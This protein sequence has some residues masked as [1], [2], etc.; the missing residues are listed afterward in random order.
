MLISGQL[1][2]S[3]EISRQSDLIRAVIIKD[4]EFPVGFSRC[5]ERH[6]A[7]LQALAAL[8]GYITQSGIGYLVGGLVVIGVGAIHHFDTAFVKTVVEIV[9]HP[10]SEARLVVGDGRDTEGHAL[11]RCVTQGS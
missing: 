6:V 9:E 8:F 7:R 4:E 10:L 5:Q 3:A 1:Y 2:L 11:K